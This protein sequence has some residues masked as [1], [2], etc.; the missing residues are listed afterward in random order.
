MCYEKAFGSVEKERKAK[1][2]LI[3]NHRDDPGE[4]PRRIILCLNTTSKRMTYLITGLK[5]CQ[6]FGRNFRNYFYTRLILIPHKFIN[7][8]K[9]GH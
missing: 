6:A 8:I 9:L 2:T 3:A 7:F 1:R 4:F 5:A